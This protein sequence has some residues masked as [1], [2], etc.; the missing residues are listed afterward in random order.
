MLPVSLDC[1]VFLLCFSPSCVP[2]VVSFSGLCCVFALFLSVLSTLCC[3]FLWIVLC[4]CFDVEKQRKNTTQSRENGNIENTRRRETKQKHNTIQRNW[5]HRVDKTERNKAKTQHNLVLCFC[6]VSLRLVYPMLPVSLDCVV[7]LL[8]FS[9]SCVPYVASFS[10]L[11]CVFALFKQKYNTIQRNWHHRVD[12]TE[13]G[14]KK[15]QHNPEKMATY[16]IVLCFCFAS[17][18]LVYPMLPVSLDCVVFCFVSLRL[19][20][21]MLPVSQDCAVFLFCFSP[22]RETKQKHNTIQRNW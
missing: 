2:Y 11:C 13:R 21:P 18:R 9:P 1:V 4:F 19:S 7:F 16:R 5:Q 6:F 12:K 10:G 15:T 20:Y 17:L 22:S 8:C 3:Q 14:K